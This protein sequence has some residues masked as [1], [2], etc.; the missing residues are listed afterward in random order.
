MNSAG[1][2]VGLCFAHKC[3]CF[4]SDTKGIPGLM[5]SSLQIQW[6]EWVESGLRVQKEATPKCKAMLSPDPP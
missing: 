5:V 4:G 1:V 2:G 6:G 3:L